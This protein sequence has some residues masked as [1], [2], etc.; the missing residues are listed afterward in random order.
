[1]T[2]RDR[3]DRKIAK[4]E[5]TRR[6]GHL[7]H[8]EESGQ[9][10]N[11]AGP[12]VTRGGGGGWAGGQ[13]GREGTKLGPNIWERRKGNRRGQANLMGISMWGKLAVFCGE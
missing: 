1:M 11:Q 10:K 4:E 3:S 9:P 8:H 7:V 6:R 13:S 12:R 2:Q 5:T